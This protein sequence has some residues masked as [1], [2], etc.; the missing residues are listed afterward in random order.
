MESLVSEYPEEF[1]IVDMGLSVLNPDPE[2]IGVQ[3]ER[4]EEGLLVPEPSIDLFG[5][6]GGLRQEPIQ[7]FASYMENY[8][9]ARDL[10]ER[11]VMVLMKVPSEEA[12]RK[13]LEGTG[14]D[15]EKVQQYMSSAEEHYSQHAGEEEDHF[16]A[17]IVND[18]VRVAVHFLKSAAFGTSTVLTEPDLLNGEYHVIRKLCELLKT[19]DAKRVVDIAIDKCNAMQ[20]LRQATEECKLVAENHPKAEKRSY[21]L[22]RATNYLERYFYL[23]AFAQYVNEQ[24][25]QMLDDMSSSMMSNSS[26]GMEDLDLEASVS[27]VSRMGFKK[28]YVAWMKERN[29]LYELLDNL[30]FVEAKKETREGT[31]RW[32]WRSKR[33]LISRLY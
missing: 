20:S 24:M 31:M 9:L 22:R 11:P 10:P 19:D 4:D 23:I 6:I 30:Y 29:D 18:D 12:L 15:E 7:L 28:S 21:Y 32:R 13:R 33:K 17:V 2:T 3:V 25:D 27:L 14:L 5:M 1:E 26:E 8:E 16:D